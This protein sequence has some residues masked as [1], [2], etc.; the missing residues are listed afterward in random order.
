MAGLGGKRDGAGRKPGSRG[1]NTK[2]A[3]L[4][5]EAYI[6]KYYKHKNK[7]WQALFDKAISGDVS[8]I[9]EANDRA[10]GKPDQLLGNDPDHPLP[11]LGYAISVDDR[12]QEDSPT[13]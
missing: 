3:A 8:A 13:P 12:N 11:I 7:I 2:L 5:K 4:L 10:M 6:K 9:K 1:Q